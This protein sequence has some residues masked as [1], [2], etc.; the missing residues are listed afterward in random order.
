MVA[1]PA[2]HADGCVL[3]CVCCNGCRHREAQGAAG[4]RTQ[5]RSMYTQVKAPLSEARLVEPTHPRCLAMRSPPCRRA[6]ATDGPH[7]DYKRASEA[8]D[9][10]IEYKQVTIKSC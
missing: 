4:A 6:V 8:G 9:P 3:V 1:C 5:V 2:V 7:I 10:L